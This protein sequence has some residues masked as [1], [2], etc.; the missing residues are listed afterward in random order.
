MS[1][2]KDT[3]RYELRRGGKIVYVGITDQPDVRAEQHST[4]GKRFTS[5]NLVGRAITR[6]SAEN[7][8]EERLETYRRHHGGK[9]PR[10]NETGK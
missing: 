10:Y 2:N 8:E 9:N 3:F 7:W 4:E 5:M 1:A 6:R